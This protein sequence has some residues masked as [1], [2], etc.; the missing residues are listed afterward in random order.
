[1][2]RP[3]TTRRG[4]TL[5][6]L[7]VV[8]AI[9]AILIGLLLPAVQKVREAASRMKCSNNLKQLSL[10]VHNYENVQ[11]N[12]PK[13]VFAAAFGDTR[14]YGLGVA[15]L[16]YLEQDALK[17][18]FDPA[19]NYDHSNNTDALKVPLNVFQCPSVPQNRFVARNRLLNP[20]YLGATTDYVSVRG[21]RFDTG[22]PDDPNAKS[23]LEP[24]SG[25]TLTTLAKPS[26]A[27]VTDGTSNS[28]VFEER[29]GLPDQW[30]KGRKIGPVGTNSNP[31]G[32]WA[33]WWGPWLRSFDDQGNVLTTMNAPC[34]IN[35]ANFAG[36][37]ENESGIYAFH[38]GGTNVAFLDGSVR[39]LR[40][41][42]TPQLLAALLSRAG[43]EIVNSNDY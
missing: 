28:L 31:F 25:A 4:F 39:F 8:I 2:S 42:I 13:H 37:N 17:N 24:T 5:I 43:G 15:L 1:V 21:T 33:S 27:L 7:L 9:I 36:T 35:C 19:V 34:I 32:S 22:I 23:A 38:T 12:L 16:P 40:E 14:E 30:I 41:S 10:A 6:E 18:K 20:N 11:K 29:A 26:L 3:S